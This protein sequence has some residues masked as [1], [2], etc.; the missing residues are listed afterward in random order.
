M[1]GSPS[2]EIVFSGRRRGG[3]GG[4]A[5]DHV[6]RR[7]TFGFFFLN[8]RR[9]GEITIAGRESP[10]LVPRPAKTQRPFLRNKGRKS[11]RASSGVSRRDYLKNVVIAKAPTTG[12][13][14]F[15]EK[16]RSS[17]S[18]VWGKFLS[19]IRESSLAKKK[20][21]HQGRENMGST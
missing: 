3:G 19:P 13:P 4:E 17:R 2:E 7:C 16:G 10:R 15:V 1:G 18:D 14:K 6:R 12:W 8:L 5:S 9:K 20:P 21:A 11:R